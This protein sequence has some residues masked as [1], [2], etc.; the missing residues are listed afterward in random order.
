MVQRPIPTKYA[1]TFLIMDPRNE[2]INLTRRDFLSTAASGLGGI[3]LASLL[4]SCGKGG[5]GIVGGP[6]SS[7]ILSGLGTP[8]FAPRAKRCIFIYMAGA[9]SQLDLFSYK[10]KLNELDGEPLPEELLKDMRFAFIEKDSVRLY[11]TKAKFKQHGQSGMWF[12]DLLPNIAKHADDICMMHSLHSDEFNHHP[13]QLM[14]Q[15]GD[16]AFGL[17]SM[18]S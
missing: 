8:H 9:P 17:P 18:G 16:G 7:T 6:A 14:M 5:S 12:S 13:G 4:G 15:C 3:A 10:P 1:Y 2:H 11:G